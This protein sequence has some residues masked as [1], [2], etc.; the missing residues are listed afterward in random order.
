MEK[1]FLSGNDIR[2]QFIEFFTERGHTAVRSASLVPAGD[3]T[4]LFT[5]AGMVQFKDV[6]LGTDKRDYKRAV[7]SQK[8]MRVA[9]K[10]NDLDEVG[11]DDTH[12]TFFEML[13]N[14]SFGDYYKKEVIEWAWT[15]LTEV[16]GLD[17]SKLWATCFKDEDSGIDA[18]SEAF[19]IW[20][21]QPGMNPDHVRYF[22]R[23]ENFWEMADTGPCGPCSEIHIDLGPER[24]NM[25]HVPGHVCSVNG[26]CSRFL[27]LWNLVF[28]QYNRISPT[29]LVPLSQK[30]VDTGMG[31][32]RIVS[33]LQNVDSNYRTDLFKSAL[34]T[35]QELSGTNEAEMNAN[36]TPYRVI[37]DHA[38]ASSF[39]IADGVVPGN[40]GRNYICRMIIRRAVRF[41]HQ[42]G[43][44]EPFMYKVAEAIIETYQGAYPELRRSHDAILSALKTE[45]ERFN[46]TLDEGIHQLNEVLEAM[47]NEGKTVVDGAVCFDLY[48]THGLPIEITY[49]LVRD[50][51]FD[52]DREGYEAA[53]EAHRLASGAG[54]AMG[55]M[56]GEEAERYGVYLSE[57]IAAGKLPST[58]VTYDPYTRQPVDTTL[59]MALSDGQ[60]Y[61]TVGEGESAELITAATNLYL[62]MG[63]QVGDTGTIR[64]KDGSFVFEVKDVRRP[65]NGL[66]LHSG[67]VVS[68]TIKPGVEVIVDIDLERRRDI[69]ANHTATHL[70]HAALH[71]VI[72][73]SA[74]QA[75]SLVAPDRLRF[76]FNSNRALTAE[77]LQRV[78]MIVNTQ[79]LAG[80]P[81][82]T[83]IENLDDAINSGVTAIFNEKYGETV[84]VLRILDGDKAVSAELCGG[85]HVSNTAEIGTFLILSEGSVATGIRR[86]EAITRRAS[87]NFIQA[88][89][90]LVHDMTRLFGVSREELLARA[91]EV[92]Q[93]LKELAKELDKVKKSA[94]LDKLGDLTAKTEV[95]NGV[96]TLMMLLPEMDSDS[97]REV[98]DRFKARHDQAV[99]VLGT[100]LND[101]V[102]FVATVTDALAKRGLSANDLIKSMTALVGGKGGGR[103]TLAQGGGKNV[104]NAETALAR[105]REM[106]Q[107]KIQ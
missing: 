20:R 40:V 98:A 84:R 13:G 16:W 18:D 44:T 36:F 50:Q 102:Q 82:T 64:A 68:G 24:C 2:K 28:M 33:I 3:A 101:Q 76:D 59:L 94:L 17:K 21:Q 35:I 23:K 81:V 104:A 47:K 79:I 34:K 87:M 63:G 54:K 6:F 11:R 4:I 37:C 10:H 8:C 60:P 14:W 106:I 71:Q 78:E 75:G 12:H 38:R 51:G 89:S 26:D 88:Q 100:V 57:L 61:D 69:Q 48:S 55:K 65:L 72:G 25:K 42:L 31:F 30:Y 77:E 85:T 74:R 91:T 39:L 53:Q 70:L 56:T 29:E 7:D 97:L 27:E 19:D 105:A 93:N 15:L 96:P 58:G 80:Y 22:G 99:T 49:D 46:K 86:I 62:E 1:K 83:S 32:E 52:V 43:L 92:H 66:I 90:G 67:T 5:N 41:G 9:G 95:I 45:E 107:E 73:D 103:P